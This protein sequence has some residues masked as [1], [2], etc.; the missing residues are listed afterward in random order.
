MRRITNQ[1]FKQEIKNLVND[2]YTVLSKYVNR[3]TKVQM[4]HNKCGNVWYVTPSS[5]LEGSRCPKCRKI[6]QS[7]RRA[8]TNEEFLNKVK[9]T[10][11]DE[12]TFLEPYQNS[13]Q[14]IKVR[15]NKCGYVW[16]TKTSNF[17]SGH[18]CPKCK[19]HKKRKS[20][21]EFL[22]EIKQLVGDEYTFLEPYQKAITKIK[23][24][25]NV[26][27]HI[28]QITPT[29][30]L[31]GNRCPYCSNR[32]TNKEFTHEV[33]QLVGN[34]Y[35]FLEP[36]Q[37][38]LIKIKA[39]HNKCGCIWSVQPASFLSGSRCPKCAGHKKRTDKEFKQEV[40]KLVGDEYTFLEPYQNRNTKIKVRHNKC[41]YVYSIAPG[42][43]LQGHKCPKCQGVIK[44]T[45]QQFKKEVSEL[46]GNEYTFFDSYQGTN[47]KLKVRHN[48][49]GNI[50][51]VSPYHFLIRNRR[52]PK[53]AAIKQH[54]QLKFTNEEF[55][56]KVVALAGDKYTFLEKYRGMHYKLKVRHNQCGYTWSVMPYQFINGSRCPRCWRLGKSRGETFVFQ[57]L[58]KL[59]YSENIDFKYAYVIKNK[60]HLDFYLP[61]LQIGIEYDGEQHFRP[62]SF[63]KA[64]LNKKQENLRK[65]QQ[66]DQRKNKYC[67]EHN[68]K[69]IRIPYTINTLEKVFNILKQ[70]IG[71][72]K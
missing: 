39:R 5:F 6:Q 15:H 2:E 52:C 53:C 58:K 30:F 3:H 13:R 28:Y 44:R 1:E 48:K 72:N 46:V 25:H 61:K 51:Y 38:A 4:R 59:N 19:H 23:V 34:E 18:R 16:K 37:S 68:I 57:G 42:S 70:K 66:R 69:L 33:K 32:K 49:C 50:Y 27:G 41:G 47:T 20:N 21:Q 24:R 63:N 29:S 9:S 71:Y 14:Y 43:F 62:F 40:K 7:Q 22:K 64:G 12:Y 60:Q 56:Q 65:V 17:F 35:T 67:A 26:C 36:Y 54:E 10:V 8:F 11:G 55:V 45:N 31:S